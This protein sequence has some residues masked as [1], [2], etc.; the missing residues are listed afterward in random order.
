MTTLIVLTFIFILGLGFFTINK[1]RLKYIQNSNFAVEYRNNFVD[2]CNIFHKTY[3]KHWS[4]GT[5][6]NDKYIWLTKNVGKIQ[7][8]IGHTGIFDSY[9]TPF[10]RMHFRNYQIIINTLP[11]FKEGNIHESDINSV[12]DCLIRYVGNMEDIID[13]VEKKMRNPIIWFKEGF[14]EILTL[15][16]YILNG[17][18]LIPDNIVSK[19]KSNLIYNII[20]GIGGL[21]AFSSAIV[22]I[23]QGKQQTIEFIQSLLRK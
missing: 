14:K 4:P 7:D 21:A 13:Q 8:I 15:P 16:I 17:F 3:E 20:I 2:F 19:I 18:G 11:K 10:Q 1:R 9:I 22:T 23:I 5:V 12:D 6:D